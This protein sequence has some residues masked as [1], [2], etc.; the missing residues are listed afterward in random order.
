MPHELDPR[1]L[2]V[3]FLSG[4][5][6]SIASAYED[7][8]IPAAEISKMFRS[9]AGRRPQTLYLWWQDIGP[10]LR[11]IGWEDVVGIQGKAYWMRK[12]QRVCGI[13]LTKPSGKMMQ[14]F[15][16]QHGLW[17]VEQRAI[18]PINRT[19]RSETVRGWK[20]QG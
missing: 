5:R 19:H 17:Q 2:E 3:K 16:E 10:H 4:L 1:T 20:Y 12:I 8:E 11:S 14:I 7:D 6:L 13:T 15:L 18:T 9:V